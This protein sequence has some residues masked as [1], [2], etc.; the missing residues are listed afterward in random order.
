[1]VLI[2][3]DR[4]LIETCADRLWLVADGTVAPFDGDLEDYR[5]KVL[6]RGEANG[7][8]RS[9]EPARPSRT[10][11]RR[12][13]AEKRAELAPLRARITRAETEIG[14]RTQEIKA[15]DAALAEPTLY[16]DPARATGLAKA[17]ADAAQA[18]SAAETDWLAAS[19]EY[20]A[21]SS[22]S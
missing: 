18:L 5:R 14:R 15:L 3:H 21:A 8:E 2:S 22:D 10:E 7:R 19:T 16:D 11:A 17:R 4:H 13:A 9:G 6:D 1:M 12:A 20:E